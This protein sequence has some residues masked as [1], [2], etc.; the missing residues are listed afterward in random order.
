MEADLGKLIR[1]IV[2]GE[3]DSYRAA[4]KREPVTT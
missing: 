3:Y 2:D 1:K 4:A